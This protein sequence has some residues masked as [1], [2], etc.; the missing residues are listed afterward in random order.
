MFNK[1]C[2]ECKQP[3]QSNT[4][5]SRKCPNCITAKE[6]YY[7]KNKEH[8]K[9]Y[10]NDYRVKNR[11]KLNKYFRSRAIKISRANAEKRKLLQKIT[12]GYGTKKCVLVQG[13]LI[14]VSKY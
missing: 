6:N 11:E 1:I 2:I 4:I 14:E 3:Y 7:Q 8:L 13:K 5:G 12:Y 9:Q 10:Q